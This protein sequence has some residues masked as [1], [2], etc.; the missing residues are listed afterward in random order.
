MIV[1][2]VAESA[3]WLMDQPAVVRTSWTVPMRAV[4]FLG[5]A[6]EWVRNEIWSFVGSGICIL[7]DWWLVGMSS[8]SGSM[9]RFHVGGL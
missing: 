3:L 1:V 5:G 2:E 4:A 8:G 9:R 6:R 7:L